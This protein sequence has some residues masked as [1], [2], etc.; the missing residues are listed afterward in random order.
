MKPTYFH[1][2]R[3]SQL[4]Q[5]S[6][7][8]VVSKRT[9]FDVI[10]FSKVPESPHWEG[11]E[12]SIANTPQQGIN[13]IGPD[14]ARR[15]VII[16]TKPG[17]YAEDG[18]VDESEGRYRY[19]FKARKGVVSLTETAN[20]VL[21]QQPEHAYPILL[22]TEQGRGWKFHGNFSVCEVADASVTLRKG[23]GSAFDSTAEQTNAP[24]SNFVEGGKKYV[25]HYLAERSKSA[26]AALKKGNSWKCEICGLDF[27]SH[28]GVA[29]IEGHHKVPL[30]SFQE[31]HVVE[32][33]D[34][35]LVCANCH[36][37][38]HLIMK[39][40]GLEY[41]AIQKMLV[42]RFSITVTSA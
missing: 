35:A 22:F 27:E 25:T 24:T 15:A 26:M 40:Q 11:T 28:Y 6:P 5:L 30:S 3:P 34:L 39:A 9:L 20:M 33:S 10:Q 17:A 41:E 4:L 14:G 16:K 37:A 2:S 1:L 36:R 32:L 31:A 21:L 13:W 12:W 7:S 23:L 19:S 8:E 42:S 38:V 29:Y 18:W